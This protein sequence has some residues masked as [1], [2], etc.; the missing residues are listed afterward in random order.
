MCQAH[1]DREREAHT[2]G[3]LDQH[4]TAIQPEVLVS[5]RVCRGIHRLSIGRRAIYLKRNS[6]TSHIASAAI[7]Q[8]ILLWPRWRSRKMI[9]TST[10]RN[11]AR[12]AR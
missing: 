7:R 11:P 9:G 8:D 1:G 10:T 6:G 5:K 2:R 12:T 4:Q 3:G